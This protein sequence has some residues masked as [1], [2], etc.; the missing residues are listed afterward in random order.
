MTDRAHDAPM[1]VSA[2]LFAE[3]SRLMPGG[4]NS[5]VRAYRAVGGTPPFLARGSGARVFD[6]DGR[7]YLD[8]VGSWGPLIAGHAHP[9][10]VRGVAET[11]ARGSSFGAPTPLEVE[12]ARTV[13]DAF[14]AVEMLRMV[15]SGT[16]ATMSALRLA[17]AATGRRLIVKFDGCYHGH[18]DSLL[19]K[20]GSGVMTLARAAAT[21]ESTARD[22]GAASASGVPTSAGVPP[23]VA[24]LTLVLPFNAPEALRALFGTRGG[25]IA[26][27][28]VEPI[29]G[30]M[31]VVLPAPGFLDELRDLC[32]RSGALL[33]FDEVITGFRVG[34]GGAQ[35]RYGIR[36]DLT[37]LGKV[38]GGGF[39]VGAYGGR[40]D[41]MTQV[42]PLGGVYQAGTLSGNPVAMRAGLETLR[43]LDEG[44]YQ[45]LD[46][47]GAALAGG[48]EGA[49]RRA[50]VSLVVN[51]V[52][53]MLTPFFADAP[54]TDAASAQRADV[55]RYARFFH[56]LLAGGVMVP[57]SQFEAWF[58]SLAHTDA[59]VRRTVDAA[60]AALAV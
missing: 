19:A 9:A 33:I 14:P 47:L 12:L 11:A 4:V 31:G 15:S 21:P 42:A 16:E 52:G 39:P 25:E 48:L 30:N 60:A 37:C 28:I 43:L 8:Y 32:A 54:V 7:E 18:V 10:V 58:V 56:G 38:I 49:A 36:P 22:P 6:V 40:R 44:A 26:A 45:R 50:R 51:R 23:E 57:P 2:A 13:V 17:R 3:A 34:R 53:S 29:P 41:V 55:T 59:D 24:A 20:A 46:A 35:A 1:P 27:V 5:P